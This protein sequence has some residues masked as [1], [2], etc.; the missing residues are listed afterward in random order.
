MRG[1]LEEN[2]PEWCCYYAITLFAGVR[3]DTTNGEMRELSRCVARDG[4]GIYFSN[5]VIRLP[6]EVTKEGDERTTTIRPNLAAW[7][8]AYPPTPK[9]ICPGIPKTFSAVR[10]MFDIPHDGLRHT[11]ISAFVSEG[12]EYSDAADQFGN[13]EPIIKRHY[14]LRMSRDEAQAFYAIYP[15]KGTLQMLT[16]TSSSVAA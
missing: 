16:Q 1:Y 4:S 10:K 15:K 5:G 14:L 8:A 11:A 12:K 13:S 9:A 6:E 7:L 3:P 2:H